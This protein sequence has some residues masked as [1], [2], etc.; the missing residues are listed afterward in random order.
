MI[1]KNRLSKFKSYN[2]PF[3]TIVID[4]FLSNNEAQEAAKLLKK[5]RIR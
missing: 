5:K 2:D 1:Y 4:N 3:P